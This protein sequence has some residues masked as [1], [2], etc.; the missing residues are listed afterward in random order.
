MTHFE[1]FFLLSIYLFLGAIITGGY[2]TDKGDE[3]TLKRLV[4][5]NGA[6]LTLIKAHGGFHNYKGKIIMLSEW[7]TRMR[8]QN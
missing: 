1:C 8:D 7:G 3:E 5:E 2:W 6:V 4:V